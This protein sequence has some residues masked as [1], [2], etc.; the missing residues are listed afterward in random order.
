MVSTKLARILTGNPDYA[1]HWTDGAGYF[2]L[3][4]EELEQG[5]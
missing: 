1:D 2:E 3:V 4:V 5:K